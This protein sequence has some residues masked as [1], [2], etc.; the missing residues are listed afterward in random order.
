LGTILKCGEGH[1]NCLVG[2]AQV[3]SY[4]EGVGERGNVGHS[5]AQEQWHCHH[6]QTGTILTCSCLCCA[7]WEP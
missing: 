7:S 3:H 5:A 4:N 2:R 6:H 1:V